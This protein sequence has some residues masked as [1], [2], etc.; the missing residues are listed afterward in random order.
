MLRETFAPPTEMQ[1]TYRSLHRIPELGVEPG[2]LVVI[3]PEHPTSPLMVVKRHDRNRLPLI[4]DHITALEP[5]S[6]DESSA[7]EGFRRQLGSPPRHRPH[8]P[9]HLKALP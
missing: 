5:V 3:R 8:R 9:H 2:D 7:S 6:S 1:R 4:L